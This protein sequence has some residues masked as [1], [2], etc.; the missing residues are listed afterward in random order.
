MKTILLLFTILT[1]TSLAQVTYPLPSQTEDEIVQAAYDRC[2]IGDVIFQE[3]THAPDWLQLCYV[4]LA[5]GKGITHVGMV[6]MMTD[7]QKYVMESPTEDVLLDEFGI[8]VIVNGNPV[9]LAGLTPLK[10]YIKRGHNKAFFVM[11]KAGGLCWWQKAAVTFTALRFRGTYYDF[12]YSFDHVW[13]P[14][15]CYVPDTYCS[16]GIY[17][18]Y[19]AAGIYLDLETMLNIKGRSPLWESIFFPSGIPLTEP[20][21]T[22][23]K[24]SQDPKLVLDQ[25]Y[26]PMSRF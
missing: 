23:L 17:Y 22:P 10:D 4:Q 3:A 14:T 11:R 12:T 20:C 16:L 1:F 24:L 7:G 13:N 18:W 19:Q 5:L 15:K 26:D 9:P 2:Q 6:V 21:L 25:I 8:P